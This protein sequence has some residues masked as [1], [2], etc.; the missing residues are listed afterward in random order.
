M[1]THSDTQNVDYVGFWAR[2]GASLIDVVLVWAIILPILLAIYGPAYLGAEKW[3]HGPMDILLSWVF[4]AVATV[5]FWQAK[6]ATPGKMLIAAK[7]VDA[8]TGQAPSLQQYL[9]RYVGYILA[10][11]PLALGIIWVGWDARKQGWH[12]KLAGTV[13]VR[14]NRRT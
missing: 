3:V 10:S 9:I 6:Q 13:V 8:R 5:A 14:V 12:D 2:V 1:D 11:L 4:P 7:V